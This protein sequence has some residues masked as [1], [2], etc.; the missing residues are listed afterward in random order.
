M[1]KISLGLVLILILGLVVGCGNT[2]YETEDLAADT[3]STYIG[4]AQNAIDTLIQSGFGGLEGELN[5][6]MKEQITPEVEEQVKTDLENKGQ[7]VEFQEAEVVKYVHK[8]TKD[9]SISVQQKTE[10]ENGNATFTV[11]YNEEGQIIGF[12]Y[13]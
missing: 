6:E 4:K 13:K 3:E 10:F 1:K 7:F 12:F 2:E 11:N 9:S 5:P 8:E